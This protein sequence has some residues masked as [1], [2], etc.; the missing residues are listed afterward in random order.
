MFKYF[1]F[2]FL[3]VFSCEKFSEDSFV[4]VEKLR[5]QAKYKEAIICLKENLNS[6][7]IGTKLK[8]KSLLKL[9]DIYKELNQ[10]K[11][12]AK[13]YEAYLKKEKIESNEKTYE[14]LLTI[15][16]KYFTLKKYNTSLKYYKEALNVSFSLDQKAIIFLK[17]GNNFLKQKNF[18]IAIF[19]YDKAIDS[20]KENTTINQKALFLKAIF[21][22]F[23]ETKDQNKNSINLLK[24]CINKNKDSYYGILCSFYLV[25]FLKKEGE[26]KQAQELLEKLEG[27]FLNESLIEIKKRNVFK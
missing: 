6:L 13:Y 27:T 17:L 1:C 18:K 15:G 12:A 14:M 23:F 2:I 9:G 26:K 19:Y 25:D 22:H 4:K 5:S 8:N 24:S 10:N 7:N 16:N 20:S 21:F 11:I 3:L